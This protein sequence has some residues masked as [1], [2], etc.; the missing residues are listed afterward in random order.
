MKEEINNR[1]D[2][3]KAKTKLVDIITIVSICK[4]CAY[5]IKKSNIFKLN[6][7]ARPNYNLCTEMHFISKG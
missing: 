1:W 4:C 2:K 6:K 3:E 7:K 5:S